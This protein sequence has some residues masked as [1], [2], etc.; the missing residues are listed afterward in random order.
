MVVE[1]QYRAEQHMYQIDIAAAQRDDQHPKGERAEIEAGEAGIL[2]EPGMSRDQPGE[3]SDG[4]PGDE[5]AK[6]HPEKRQ[7]GEQKAE[8]GA[9]QDRMGHGVAGQAHAAQ[10]QEHADRRPADGQ[11]RGAGECSA[12]EAEFDEGLDQKLEHRHEANLWQIAAPSSKASPIRLAWS[13]F[14]GCSTSAV[15][16]KAIGSRA[17]YRVS[18]KT[19][20]TVSRSCQHDQQ[21]ALLAVPALD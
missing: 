3:N 21:G 16:P 17:R 10:H 1:R 5:P 14:S 9:R 7:A 18:G 19:L 2:G 13:W 20:R 6:R 12:H 15:G 4:Q 8:G 11:R